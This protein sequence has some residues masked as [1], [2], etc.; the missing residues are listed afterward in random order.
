MNPSLSIQA[1][2]FYV[3]LAWK[4]AFIAHR[5]VL[6]RETVQSLRLLRASFLVC[7]TAVM[8]PNMLRQFNQYSAHGATSTK[9]NFEIHTVCKY[10]VAF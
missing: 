5:G 3:V 9:S 10:G 4:V 1:L 2:N 6:A 7:S 8:L